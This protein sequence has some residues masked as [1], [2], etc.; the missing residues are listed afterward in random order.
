MGL[1]SYANLEER[2]ISATGHK[3]FT[4]DSKASDPSTI[5]K[6]ITIFLLGNFH[7][8]FLHRAGLG[9]HPHPDTE[10]AVT[11]SKGDSEVQSLGK[12]PLAQ[13]HKILLMQKIASCTPDLVN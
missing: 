10:V 6:L 9:L 1:K 2:L 11:L 4:D 13:G 7:P 3:M 5:G 8:H 12:R